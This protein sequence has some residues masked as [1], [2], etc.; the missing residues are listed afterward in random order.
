MTDFNG[1]LTHQ[2]LIAIKF[3]L[4]FYSYFWKNLF[5]SSIEYE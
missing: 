4:R 1:M 5:L 3:I 2:R